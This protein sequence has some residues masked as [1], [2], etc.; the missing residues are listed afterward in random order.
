MV[1]N[2]LKEILAPETPFALGAERRVILNGTAKPNFG[3]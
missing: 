1:V 3:S 2:T